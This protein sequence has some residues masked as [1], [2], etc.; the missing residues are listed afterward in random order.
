MS[1]LPWENETSYFPYVENTSVAPYTDI[2]TEHRLATDSYEN[3]PEPDETDT[4]PRRITRPTVTLTALGSVTLG[5]V[6]ASGGVVFPNPASGSVILTPLTSSGVATIPPVGAGAVTAPVIISSGAVTV[7][8]APSG[9]SR[10][11]TVAEVNAGLGMYGLYG[12]TGSIDNHLVPA[13]NGNTYILRAYS[14]TDSGVTWR[15]RWNNSGTGAD[16][17]SSVSEGTWTFIDVVHSAGTMRLDF[18]RTSNG[19]DIFLDS[20]GS[21]GFAYMNAPAEWDAGDVGQVR[22]VI[23]IP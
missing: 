14:R 5:A 8:G 4:A 9:D 7:T 10:F 22:E 2:D 3:P 6:E 19:G 11:V 1:V 15:L 18:R 20:F 12:T 21:S 16:P 17:G 23:F 13:N